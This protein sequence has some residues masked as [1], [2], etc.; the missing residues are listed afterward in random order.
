MLANYR[1]NQVVCV[2]NVGYP[3]AHCLIDS[4]LECALAI[5]DRN[6]SG[7]QRV[8]AEHVELLPLAI[9]GAH[10]DS[11]VQAEHSC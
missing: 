7:T 9:N 8:H 1:A 2:A 11:A 4:I 6:N 3:V 10:V 5:L